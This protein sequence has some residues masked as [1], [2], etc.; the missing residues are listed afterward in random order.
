MASLIMPEV[1]T[2]RNQSDGKKSMGRTHPADVLECVTNI[3]SLHEALAMSDGS[4]QLFLL[5]MFASSLSTT[6]DLIGAKVK[7]MWKVGLTYSSQFCWDGHPSW[8]MLHCQ[9]R[10]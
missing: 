4:Q 3:M 5:I 9:G 7:A 10:P 2:K 8:T 6:A 1:H